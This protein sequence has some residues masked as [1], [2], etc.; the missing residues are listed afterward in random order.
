[1]LCA[2]SLILLAL[3]AG[4]LAAQLP[5][6]TF[7]SGARAERLAGLYVFEDGRLAQVMDLRDQLD[8]RPTL[9]VVEY[10]SG[11]LRGLYP[12]ASGA[13]EAGNA[14][15]RR[16]SVTYILRFDEDSG[17]AMRVTWDEAGRSVGGRRAPLVER[18]VTILNGDVTLAGTLILPGGPGPHPAVVMVHGSGP[19]TRR[20]P[21]YVGDLLAWHGIAVL[22]MDKRGT[23][24]ST[25]RW[26]ALSHADWATDVEAQ[27]DFLRTVPEI[28]EGRLG[29]IAG[30]EGGFVAPVVAARRQ[31]VRF[32]VC[33]VCSA[34]PH[35]RVILD[36]ETGTLRRRGM[37][38][39]DVDKAGELLE[40]LMRYAL[41][42]TGYDSLVAFADAGT[43]APWR[44]VFPMERIPAANAAYW[45]RYRGALVVDPR[46]YYARLSIP[47]LAILGERDER[48]LVERHRP[49]FQAL[50]NAGIDVS[51][52]VI[53]GASH[54]LLIPGEAPTELAYPAD[55]HQRIVDW[56]L[57]VA[58]D[59]LDR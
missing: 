14:W 40:R 6:T 37:A 50:A 47:V 51:V 9:S 43:G 24:G 30:S 53:S 29:L 25:G 39:A 5:D 34:L 54:G 36:M 41:D 3:A 1:V 11:R 35:P 27:L 42:R 12:T 46:D 18:D 52:W 2:R 8:G 31:D 38:D 59:D 22:A 4:P 10:A 15:F 55:L 45:D 28:D 32:L 49:A 19:L 26:L 16:D 21:R 23:G 48:I 7:L 44:A 57:E 20:T 56:V 13:F 17:R 58:H 33:R